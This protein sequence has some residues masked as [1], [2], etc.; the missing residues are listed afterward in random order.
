MIFITKLKTET[1][2]LFINIHLNELQTKIK[3]KFRNLEHYE[4]I[5]KIK[6]KI[7]IFEKI[8]KRFFNIVFSR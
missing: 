3:L 8:S 1:Y 5:E 4:K 7:H 6:K 2:I